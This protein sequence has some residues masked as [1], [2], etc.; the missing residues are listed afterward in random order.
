MFIIKYFV[1][2]TDIRYFILVID[3]SF[4]TFIKLDCEIIYIWNLK[5]KYRFLFC[6]NYYNNSSCMQYSQM[7]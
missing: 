6:K 1:E 7:M 3:E 2:C 5:I 4:L